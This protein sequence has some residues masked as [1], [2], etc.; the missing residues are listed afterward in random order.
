MKHTLV[1]AAIV[2]AGALVAAQGRI[3]SESVAARYKVG[4]D[5]F[6]GDVRVTS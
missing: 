6:G 2:A 3:E 5:P 1:A 4:T